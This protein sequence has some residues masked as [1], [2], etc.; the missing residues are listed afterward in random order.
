[1]ESLKSLDQKIFQL[2]KIKKIKDLRYRLK[3]VK[4]KKSR[5]KTIPPDKTTFIF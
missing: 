1:M 5:R 4:T 3:L 2:K